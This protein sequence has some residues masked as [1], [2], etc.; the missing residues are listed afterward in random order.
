MEVI[1]FTASHPCYA[2]VVIDYLDPGAKMVSHRLYRDNCWQTEEGVFV[3]DLR[4][5]GNRNLSDIVLVDNA[6]YSYFFQMDNGIPIIPYYEGK[7]DFELKHLIDYIVEIE[8]VKDVREV[9]KKFFKLDKYFAFSDPQ[10][11]SR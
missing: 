7:N 11:L 2:N 1:I 3:K 10:E 6:A 4:I 8:N 5:L 9:N